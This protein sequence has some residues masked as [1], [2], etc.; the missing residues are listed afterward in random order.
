MKKNILTKTCAIALIGASISACVTKYAD[1]KPVIVKK[2]YGIWNVSDCMISSRRADI[3]L[4]S[5]ARLSAETYRVRI[6]SDVPLEGIPLVRHTAQPKY[7]PAVEGANG[8][9]SFD[10]PFHPALVSR[11]NKQDGFLVITYRPAGE[12]SQKKQAYFA[13]HQ[14]ADALTDLSVSPCVK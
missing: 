6:K 1:E 14:L 9:F 2:H 8:V 3:S 11:L 12:G 10:V 13:T 7:V 5:D 4:T